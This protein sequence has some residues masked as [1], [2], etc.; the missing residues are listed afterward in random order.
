MP[1]QLLIILSATICLALLLPIFA[2]Q[3]VNGV[4]AIEKAIADNRLPTA[5]SMVNNDVASF[6]ALGNPDTL[7]AYIPLAGKIA[8][9]LDGPTKAKDR[10]KEF[11]KTLQTKTANAA[12]LLRAHQAAAEFFGSIGQN[13]YGYESSQEALTIALSDAK[14]SPLQIAQCEYNLG[15][16]AQR[17]GNVALSQ[18]HH[19]RAMNIRQDQK[20][21]PPDDMYLS[22]NAMGVLMWYASK[23]DSAELYFNQALESLK[24]MPS[25][26]LNTFFRPANVWNNMAAVYSAE[27]KT[28]EAI[29]AMEVT[30]ANFQ[31]FL[32]TKTPH[33]KKTS[34]TE[35]L[36]EGIDNLAGI[37]REIGDFGKGGELL[38]YSYNKKL[39][40]LD[41]ENPGIFISE[42]LLG[43][44]YQGIHEYD[45]AV[46]Y[47]KSGLGK[48]QKSEG[49]YL[50]WAAD[51]YYNLAMIAENQGRMNE[52]EEYYSKSE[53]LYEQSYQGDYD[54]IYMGF[55]RSISLFYAKNNKYAAAV[56]RA[57]KVY[58]YL[59]AVGAKGS[60]QAFYQVLNIAEINYL[61]KRYDDAIQYSVNALSILRHKM[62]DKITLL[63]SVKMEVFKPK[64][65]LI[66]AKS[67]Y[68]LRTERDTSFLN[69]IAAQLEEASA[70]LQKRKVL[71]DDPTSIHILMN[72][73]QNLIDFAKQLQLELYELTGRSTNLDRF[74]N[75]HE[76]A[77][78]NRIRARLDKEQAI[79]FARLPDSILQEEDSLKSAIAGSLEVDVANGHLMDNYLEAVRNWELYLVKLKEQYPAY[80]QMRYAPVFRSLAAMQENLPDST[81]VVRYVHSDGRLMA[82]VMD[83]HN[84]TLVPVDNSQLED[85][86]SMLLT[87]NNEKQQLML[88][89]ELY[90]Q[91]WQPL[92][93]YIHSSRVVIIPDGVLYNLSFEMLANTAVDQ[94]LSL[95]SNSLLSRHAIVYHYSLF[96]LSQPR[97]NLS[98]KSNYVGFTPGFSD[99]LKEQYI[100]G[101]ED[102]I[103]LDRRYLTLLPQPGVTRLAQ[104]IKGML[105]G[106]IFMNE[107][108]TRTTFKRNAGGHNII[109]I[110][111][112]AEYNNIR[113]EQSGLVFSKNTNERSESNFLALREIYNCNMQSD[114]TLLTACESGKHG[115]QDGEGMISL[116]HAFNY[117]GSQR[118][119]TALWKI[120]EQSSSRITELFITNL[121]EGV[122]T[123][124]A[125]RQAK[126]QYLREARGRTVAPAYWA[127]LVIIGE[128]AKLQLSNPQN[129]IYWIAGALAILIP[130]A[131]IIM[132]LQR[133]R[134]RFAKH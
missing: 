17:L 76:S 55:L 63:D 122:A 73:H 24:K 77:L 84:K 75:L 27:G 13:Q 44:H 132:K 3:A 61:N 2:Q 16:Y 18:S 128:P 80:Y 60:L 99:E 116:A 10:L 38:R 32:D 53:T 108:S 85:K 49:D 37:Y 72:D 14:F 5:D 36:F 134:T 110:G 57:E 42:I 83:K 114:L 50:F 67:E 74:I 12:L 95:A 35:G 40:A 54:N 47:L 59:V 22:A 100:A 9:K 33:P 126:L 23:Y 117:A 98:S 131:V 97:V 48:L 96:M 129:Y 26:D 81:T 31:K 107:G 52:A 19:K 102:S 4:P 123:D 1:R 133:R 88:L 101:I 68:L 20:Y 103:N 121:K 34:A 91:L 56:Q 87:F 11:I 106:E 29:H 127:G 115:Y 89:H 8:N 25:D 112:H 39:Q 30:I 45:S 58:D 51:A 109:H 120:D 93:P 86:I 64:A 41:A 118:I 78:Y 69:R 79:R 104:K 15:V 65:L 46:H 124:E 7:I 125:L 90:E 66:R 82:L 28:S 21:A 43:Q 105:G 119:L 70:I 111:T 130:L 6:L 113:P 94:Y 62:K 71:V 92:V